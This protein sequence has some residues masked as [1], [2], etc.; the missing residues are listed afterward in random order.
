MVMTVQRHPK[1]GALTHVSSPETS[2]SR[3]PARQYFPPVAERLV[4]VADAARILGVHA[5]TLRAWSDAGRVPAVRIHAQGQR[6]YHRAD[7]A[8]FLAHAATGPDT[9]GPS[10]SRAVSVAG[11]ARILGVHPNTVR[12]WSDQGRLAALRIN[13]RGDRRFRMAVLE[14]FMAGATGAGLSGRPE[15]LPGMVGRTW[16]SSHALT[17]SS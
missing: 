10:G 13:D 1:K 7:L 12:A 16:E 8:A 15:R 6:R 3:F 4:S 14:A 2:T 11:A 17:L 5:N 9:G